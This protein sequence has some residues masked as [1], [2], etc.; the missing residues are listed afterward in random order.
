MSYHNIPNNVN[1]SRTNAQ[2]KA[3]PPGFHYMPD[4]SLMAD[5]DMTPAGQDP[6]LS[7]TNSLSNLQQSATV[8][9]CSFADIANEA[10]ATVAPA[11]LGYGLPNANSQAYINLFQ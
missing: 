2:G 7:T 4:G 5:S 1:Q 9:T 8:V 6:G 3:A 10:K 11:Y